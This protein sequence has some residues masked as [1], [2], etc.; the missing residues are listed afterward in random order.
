MARKSRN[1]VEGRSLSTRGRRLNDLEDVETEEE[2][3]R[4]LKEGAGFEATGTDDIDE[5]ES[6]AGYRPY[7]LEPEEAFGSLGQFWL[8][9]N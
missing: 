8:A 4:F 7:R 2:L 3:K 1:Q 5:Q 6:D 9:D